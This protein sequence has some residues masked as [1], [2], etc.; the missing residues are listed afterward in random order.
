MNRHL[1]FNEI[2][3]VDIIYEIIDLIHTIID[4]NLDPVTD[5]IDIYSFENTGFCIIAMF[6][7]TYKGW[8]Y[9]GK[10]R[11]RK[12]DFGQLVKVSKEIS[13]RWEIKKENEDDS[14]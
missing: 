2:E 5:D 9:S 10:V 3:Y 1:K 13:K 6:N 12:R 11:L 14:V 7:Y 4:P 8:Y